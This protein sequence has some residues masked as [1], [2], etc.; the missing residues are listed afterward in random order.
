[1]T[2]YSGAEGALGV[3]AQAFGGAEG[4]G[5][6]S[7]VI[8]RLV[9]FLG[10]D[11]IARISAQSAS[12]A[13]PAKLPVQSDAQSAVLYVSD[14]SVFYRLDGTVPAVGADQFIVQGSIVILTGQPSLQNFQFVSAAAGPANIFGTFFT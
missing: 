7:Q 12:S 8:Q 9:R 2:E 4:G 14:N 13:N 3:I 6:A 10:G 5:L 1:M 11:P